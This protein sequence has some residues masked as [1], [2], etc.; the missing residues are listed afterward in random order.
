MGAPQR[1]LF[2]FVFAGLAVA[3]GASLAR[4]DL[5]VSRFPADAAGCRPLAVGYESFGAPDQ[6]LHQT[7]RPNKH[8][9]VRKSGLLDALAH[10]MALMSTVLFLPPESGGGST[11]TTTGGGSPGTGTQGNP[12]GP[13]THSAPEPSTLLAGLIGAGA[14]TMFR[15]VRARRQRKS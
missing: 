3:A 11:T 2:L 14:V 15:Y 5:L 9:Q 13:G 10:R 8:T 1:S 12:S 6:A 7:R 4:A